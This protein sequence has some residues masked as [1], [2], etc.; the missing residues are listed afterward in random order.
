MKEIRIL[1]RD[2]KSFPNNWFVYPQET[3]DTDREGLVVC[4]MDGE[5]QG[6][7]DIGTNDGKVITN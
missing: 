6:F 2:L 4:N 3:K 1:I 7:I 5:E